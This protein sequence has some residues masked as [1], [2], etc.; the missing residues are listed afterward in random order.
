MP[1]N[2]AMQQ[3]NQVGAQTLQ[4]SSSGVQPSYSQGPTQP[5]QQP[6][7]GQ[8]G[9]VPAQPNQM[10]A[11]GGQIGSHSSALPNAQSPYRAPMQQG[12]QFGPPDGLMPQQQ[13]QH[14][15]V[16]TVQEEPVSYTPKPV[17]GSGIDARSAPDPKVTAEQQAA[18]TGGAPGAALG[19]VPLLEQALACHLCEFLIESVLENPKLREVRDPAAAKVHSIDLVKL[20][21]QDPGYGPKFK[22][23]LDEIPAW[24]KYKSQDHSLLITGHEQKADYFLTDGS[25]GETKLLT[26]K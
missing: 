15:I 14:P 5:Y 22:L 1:S 23:V 6:L 16:E 25:S 17:E 4:A 9:G 3:Q 7:P 18:S 13:Q 19:R 11:M 21:S 26:D 24:K 12:A 10:Q 2:A 8:P 20:L